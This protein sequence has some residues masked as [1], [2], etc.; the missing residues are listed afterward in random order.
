MLNVP[1]ANIFE[2]L[3]VNLGTA[4]VNDFNAFGRVYPGPGAGRRRFRLRAEDIAALKVRSATGA[5]V[6]LGTLVAI[7]RLDRPDLRA[8]LQHVSVGAACRVTP[9][10]ASRSGTA[11]DLMEAAAAETL[12]R[13]RR[14]RMDRARLPGAQRRQHGDLHL[15]PLGAV[16]LPRA[17]GAI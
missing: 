14:L 5:L 9:R 2:T 3:Q 16:R 15:R 12:P 4:Y 8:A 17:G 13:G 6:P 1:I 11:L 10:R 7:T